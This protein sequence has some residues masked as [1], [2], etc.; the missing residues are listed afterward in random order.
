MRSTRPLACGERAKIRRTPSSASARANWVDASP[1]A[2]CWAEARKTEAAEEIG[3]L[4][5]QV[6]HALPPATPAVRARCA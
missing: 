4:S 3:L 2:R 1:P 6:S 5:F